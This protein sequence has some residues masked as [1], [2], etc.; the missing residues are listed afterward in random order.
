MKIGTWRAQ[1]VSTA[2]RSASLMAASR[3]M[4]RKASHPKALSAVPA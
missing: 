3:L 4:S 1:K 2:C